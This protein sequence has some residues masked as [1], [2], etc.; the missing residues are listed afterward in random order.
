MSA[1]RS[2][3]TRARSAIVHRWQ[4]RCVTPV[5]AAASGARRAR[6]PGRFAPRQVPPVRAHRPR[7]T[8]CFGR[9]MHDVLRASAGRARRVIARSHD[10][11]T[12]EDSLR[13]IPAASSRGQARST[14][15][16]VLL[17]RLTRQCSCCGEPGQTPQ[18]AR[19]AARDEERQAHCAAR[20]ILSSNPRQTEGPGR[21][22]CN[23][24]PGLGRVRVARLRGTTSRA[25]RTPAALR[26]TGHPAVRPVAARRP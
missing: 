2:G 13:R 18:L 4:P 23:R 6:T 15:F 8:T 24:T 9:L 14:C 19:Q 25:A 7:W 26:R 11:P 5:H 10:C 17:R 16:G 1:L 12:A 20:C 21:H 3:G 22:G